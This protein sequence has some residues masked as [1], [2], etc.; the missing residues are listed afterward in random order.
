M[1]NHWYHHRG[2][3]SVYLRQVGVRRA[4]DLRPERGREP[5]RLI[6][7]R[8]PSNQHPTRAAHGFGPG[9]PPADSLA[10][11]S[12][13]WIIIRKRAG[14]MVSLASAGFS[15][16]EDSSNRN[17]SGH[18]C[19]SRGQTMTA[20]TCNH[21]LMGAAAF[22]CATLFQLGIVGAEPVTVRHREGV[23]HGFLALKT[24]DDVTLADGDVTSGSPAETV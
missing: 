17:L 8:I 24:M 5:V 16:L 1:L 14:A 13:R 15:G 23:L 10:L 7:F 18:G 11:R 19:A 2:Q 4:V 6:A 3:L 20:R 21:R 9:P 22:T 12:I